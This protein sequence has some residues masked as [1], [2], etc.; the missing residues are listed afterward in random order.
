[1]WVK[2]YSIISKCP[3][4][5]TDM[6]A[7]ILLLSLIIIIHP[8]YRI[9]VSKYPKKLLSCLWHKI[10]ACRLA[11]KYMSA[12]PISKIANLSTMFDLIV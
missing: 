2:Y 12:Q 8:S 4:D 6:S 10:T 3:G 1:M 11:E 5:L 7:N 9:Q